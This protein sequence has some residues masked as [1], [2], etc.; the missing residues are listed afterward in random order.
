MTYRELTEA[1]APYL[2]AVL[3]DRVIHYRF[4]RH[5]KNIIETLAAIFLALFLVALAVSRA[6]ADAS[7]FA[8]FRENILPYEPRF[9]GAFL[10]C[11]ALWAVL[12]AMNA[13]YHSFYF[14]KID[15]IVPEPG[16]SPEG[17]PK[18]T[19]AVAA[20]ALGSSG[21]SPAADFI[22]SFYGRM[23]LARLGVGLPALAAFIAKR[24]GAPPAGAFS[25]APDP[26]RG[27]V[28]LSGFAV[29]LGSADPGFVEFLALYQAG[30]RELAG[31]AAWVERMYEQAHLEE[32]WWGRDHLGRI[33]GIGKEWSFGGAY[34]LEKY[35]A[36]I[37][38][39]G[40]FAPRRRGSVVEK[41]AVQI[42]TILCRAREANALL[43]APEGSERSAVLRE[44]GKAIAN[45]TIM[46]GLEYM[47][48]FLFDSHA[49]VAATKSKAAFENSLLSLLDEAARAGNVI[50]VMPDF[51]EFVREG[52]TIGSNVVGILDPYLASPRLHVVGIADPATFHARIEGNGK[53]MA[54][55]EKVLLEEENEET[56]IEAVED[57]A[58]ALE[59]SQGFFFTYQSILAVVESAGRY[60]ADGVMPDKALH[61]LDEIAPRL[62]EEKKKF[63]AGN[64]IREFVALKTGIPSGAVSRS[65][66][67]KLLAL[68]SLLHE[69]IIGQDEA[70][71]AVANAL[72]RARTNIENPE[73][74]M[75]SFLFLGPTGVGK[76]ETAKALASVF[77]GREDAIIRFDM[78]EYRS[79]D[80]LNRLIGSFE[81][82]KV[83]ALAAKL[84]ER[85]YGVLLL[86]EFEKASKDVLDLFLQ[87]LDE[88][89]FS[90][91]TGRKVNARNLIIIATSNAG[92]DLIG[93]IMKEKK[94]L[95]AEKPRIVNAIIARG[96]FKPELLNRFDGI[97]LF[98]PLAEVHLRQIA[99][100]MLGKLG[101]R[102]EGRGITLVI[103]E[104]LIA[105]V[106]AGGTDPEFGARPMNR[107]I[108]EK[109]EQVIARKIIE[110][111][112]APGST[113]ALTEADLS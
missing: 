78:S 32:R 34:E 8:R 101:K 26:K 15:S 74:P 22:R 70:V 61:L 75:G 16:F 95:P 53:L 5:A 110:G 90:D 55:F 112:A 47:R 30:R 40:L 92:S 72:R 45:G 108:Q 37:T 99:A 65:E 12:A 109:V 73:R 60:L 59:F 35:A 79:D 111:T 82:G 107:A 77:F 105:A 113:I 38:G 97:V 94:D 46:P 89:F 27:V 58:A 98:H 36:D 31:A 96:I 106:M 50:L 3:F 56:T 1:S 14:K 87:I 88:G 17:A 80:A 57:E 71:S 69:R 64:D 67:D 23:V 86:D 20:V 28:T 84:R 19:Y 54:R 68:E 51:A 83:G 21:G 4:R 33:P 41:A 42:E 13:F 93:S 44:L 48:L 25:A 18:V 7:A 81:G 6:P 62:R 52:E 49:F 63:I 103:N 100:L 10:M 91:M 102:L 43:V 66:Q 29:A 2:P 11:A 39:E 85:P 9:L 104:P 24:E 76:T